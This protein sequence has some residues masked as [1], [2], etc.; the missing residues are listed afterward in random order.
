MRITT[1]FNGEHH[2]VIPLW[3]EGGIEAFPRRGV[4]PCA[5][6]ARYRPDSVKVGYESSFTRC[7]YK[8]KPMWTLAEIR[9]D[10]LALEQETEGLL[11]E[12]VGKT[13]S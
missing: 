8:P 5:A 11:T 12:I 4:L 10:I 6:N 3:E 1:R 7:F 9:A 13:T 2:E